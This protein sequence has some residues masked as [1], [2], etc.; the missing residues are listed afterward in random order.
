M[1]GIRILFPADQPASG[2][3]LEMFMKR[4]ILR[5]AR[6]FPRAIPALRMWAFLVAGSLLLAPAACGGGKPKLLV[7]D[8]VFV[9]L[10]SSGTGEFFTT[11]E[12]VASVKRVSEALRKGMAELGTY[13]VLPASKPAG[14]DEEPVDLTCA[15]CVLDIA[16]AQ[17]A[18]FI[19]T[20]A[21]TRASSALQFLKVELDN[22]ATEK[23]VKVG[24]VQITGISDKQLEKAALFAVES[25]LSETAATGGENSPKATADGK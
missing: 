25:V 15:H 18:D 19:L 22:V 23:A 21:V 10:M 4:E 7:F 16:R 1:A 20:S 9:D 24:T 14:E 2:H 17:H 12:E 11:P 5:N 6:A 13:Q 3:N 8:T